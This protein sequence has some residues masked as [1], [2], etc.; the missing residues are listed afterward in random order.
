M[1]FIAVVV[2][3]AMAARPAPADDPYMPSAT[4]ITVK[5]VET[6]LTMPPDIVGAC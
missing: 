2:L 3:V 6:M 4:E 1:V 5:I